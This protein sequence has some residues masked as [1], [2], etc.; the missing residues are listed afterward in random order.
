MTGWEPLLATVFVASLVL[1]RWPGKPSTSKLP[2]LDVVIGLGLAIGGWYY[3]RFWLNALNPTWV[4]HGHDNHD[5]Y[6]C[7]V[8]LQYGEP[9]L[10]NAFRYPLYPALSV[11]LA[12]IADMPLHR[13]GMEVSL[14]SSALVPV[15]VFVLGRA[16][17]IQ[18]VA[19][20]GAL[21]T[22]R[23]SVD[24]MV[25]GT[26]TAY[27]LATALYAASIGAL[28]FSIRDGGWIR[29]LLAGLTLAAY[30]A[31]TAKAFPMLWAGGVAILVTASLRERRQWQSVALFFVPLIACWWIFSRSGLRLHALEGLIH[32]VQQQW[33]ML[34]PEKPFPDFGWSPTAQI[35]ER[36]FWVVGQASSFLHLDDVLR[37]LLFSPIHKLPLTDAL[38]EVNF[39][40]ALAILMPGGAAAIPVS[41]V[42]AG[43]AWAG[44]PKSW[45]RLFA[46]GLGLSTVAIHLWGLANMPFVP[47]WALPVTFTTPMLLLAT[48]GLAAR[49]ATP[50]P[51]RVWL[52]TLPALAV[53]IWLYLFSGLPFSAKA[54]H[55]YVRI[56]AADP[57]HRIAV[58]HDVLPLVRPGD[59]VVDA[60]ETHLARSL[61][62][63][64]GVEFVRPKASLDPQGQRGFKIQ[65]TSAGQRWILLDCMT[66]EN[67]QPN[68]AYTIVYAWF[69]ARPER[70]EPFGECLYRDHTPGEP[71]D[72]DPATPPL[73]G[74]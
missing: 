45:P 19:L 61:F 39:G 29:H 51:F 14:A 9:G 42:G 38:D 53:L 69:A 46:T 27:P 68:H 62:D 22:L 18:P 64:T 16:I 63:R 26:P 5:Y 36:G 67:L 37:F 47:Y 17:S 24:P 4:P 11:L 13:A 65:P 50:S 2:W 33:H 21:V 28:V 48:A 71:I 73:S 58:I 8:A 74:Q 30:M 34:D 31:T 55:E 52:A 44:G 10:W 20:I 3:L 66:I 12:W 35:S 49:F 72:T 70:F 41:V 40:I 54:L 32:D 25:L 1:W 57:P 6:K 60:S 15:G 23:L 59:Q 56:R 7:M 43:G